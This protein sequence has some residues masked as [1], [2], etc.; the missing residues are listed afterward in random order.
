M[1]GKRFLQIAVSV[2]LAIGAVGVFAG[3]QEKELRER[4]L[5]LQAQMERQA[6]QIGQLQ[7]QLDETSAGQEVVVV[8]PAATDEAS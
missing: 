1:K 5:A 3:C 7:R 4:N 2:V 8:E 6:I